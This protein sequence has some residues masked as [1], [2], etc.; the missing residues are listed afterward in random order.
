MRK[1]PLL[2]IAGVMTAFCMLFSGVAVYG[3]EIEAS[4]GEV[5][6]FEEDNTLPIYYPTVSSYCYEHLSEQAKELYRNLLTSCLE[7]EN[8]SNHYEITPLAKRPSAIS[9]TELSDVVSIFMYDHPEFFWLGKSFGKRTKGTESYVY[10]TLYEQYYD[11]TARNNDRV[12]I[13][14]MISYYLNTALEQPTDYQRAFYLSSRL[15]SDTTYNS[16]G[17]TQSMASVFLGTRQTVCA[18]YTKAF[19]YLCNAVG[20]NTISMVGVNHAWNLVQINDV[21][22]Y[23]VVTNE[24]RF[25]SRNGMLSTKFARDN[26]SFTFKYLDDQ[27]VRDESGNVK[28]FGVYDSRYYDYN[29]IFPDCNADY[30]GLSKQMNDRKEQTKRKLKAQTNYNIYYL[31]ENKQSMQVSDLISDFSITNEYTNGDIISLDELSTDGL[32]IKEGWRAPAEIYSHRRRGAKL[33]S[34]RDSVY[35]RRY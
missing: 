5:T 30:T 32:K 25:M 13:M 7:V 15:R 14:D 34:W 10:L 22:Y 8:S 33:L 23:M 19:S 11:G 6:L 2:S 20:V 16:N 29:D 21:W 1:N 28:L 26:N 12:Q 3:E 35:V 27:Y 18:G 9:D 4:T 31:A 24:F 17:N